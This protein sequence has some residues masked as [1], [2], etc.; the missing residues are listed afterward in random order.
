[1]SATPTS[2]SLDYLRKNGWT[3]DVV[4]RWLPVFGSTSIRKDYLGC[5]DLIAIQAGMTL[6]VQ[7]T[8]AAN[9]ASRVRKISASEHLATMKSAGWL[10]CV[11]GWRKSPTGKWVVREVML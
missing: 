10:V 3:V 9:V 11:Q 4:E 8:S 2:R 6:A 1:M 7:V 5:I